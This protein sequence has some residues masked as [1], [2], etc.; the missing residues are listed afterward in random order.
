[1]LIFQQN[2]AAKDPGVSSVKYFIMNIISPL[3]PCILTIYK[4]QLPQ[5][6]QTMLCFIKKKFLK[7]ILYESVCDTTTLTY[8]ISSTFIT[9]TLSTPLC[10]PHSNIPVQIVSFLY[11][12][13]V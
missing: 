12:V 1:M 11:C 10:M 2:S 9:I 4:A 5:K 6:N 8:L 13:K 3:T 7:L